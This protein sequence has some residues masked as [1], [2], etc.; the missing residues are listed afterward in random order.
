MRI[1]IARVAVAI[2]LMTLPLLLHAQEKDAPTV[3]GRWTMTADTGAHGTR[4]MELSL[5]QSGR[6]VSGTFASPH[7]DLPVKGEFVDRS[8]ELKTTSEGHGA[9]LAF[10][11]TLKDDDTLKGYVSSPDGDITFVAKRVTGKQ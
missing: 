11:A 6:E 5:K 8:L 10:T 7:G 3:A 2:G 1:R 4:T 9:T